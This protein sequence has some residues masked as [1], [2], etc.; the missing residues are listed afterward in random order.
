MREVHSTQVLISVWVESLR[1]PATG[2]RHPQV[3][4]VDSCVRVTWERL[5]LHIVGHQVFVAVWD[6]PK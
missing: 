1:V 3:E 4:Q 6:G 2:G 5:Q